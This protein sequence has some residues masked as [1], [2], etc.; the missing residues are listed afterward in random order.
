MEIVLTPAMSER[1][2]PV[3]T[4]QDGKFEDTESFVLELSTVEDGVDIA[5]SHASVNIDDNGV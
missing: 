5:P 4:S 1:C 2:I 3:V